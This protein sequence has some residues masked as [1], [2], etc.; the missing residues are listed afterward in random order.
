M[1]LAPWDETRKLGEKSKEIGIIY[2]LFKNG[3]PGNCIYF[4]SSCYNMVHV[5]KTRAL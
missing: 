4:S 5:N 1:L 2:Y 3:M